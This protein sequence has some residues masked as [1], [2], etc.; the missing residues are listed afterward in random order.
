MP[1]MGRAQSDGKVQL[2]GSVQ[3]EFTVPEEDKAIGT[4]PS[5][6]DV[7]NNTYIDLGLTSKYID[8]GARLE[9]MEHPLQGFEEDFKGWGVPHIYIKGRYKGMEL[10]VGDYYEQFGSGLILRS[11]EERS[12]GIDNS[13]RGGRLKVDAIKGLHLT[14]LAGTQRRY[15]D[16]EYKNCIMGADAELSISDLAPA[17]QEKGI[18]W[19]IGG[20]WVDKY[21]HEDA[22]NM[23]YSKLNIPKFTNSFDVRSRLQ[24]QNFS[25]LAEYAW[26]DEDPS[27]VNNYTYHRG[28]AI[29]VSASYSKT[30]FSA[31]VQAKRSE[32]MNYR[33]QRAVSGTSCFVNH[34]PAFAYQHTYS[35]AALYPYSTQYGSASAEYGL[36]PGEWAFQGEVAY[37]FKKKTALGGKYG[38]KLKFNASHIRGL[39]YELTD[40]V[41]GSLSGTD[42]YK[43]KFFGTSN[44]S[45]YEDYNIQLDKKI[46]KQLKVNAMYMYQKYNKTVVE[47]HGGNVYSHIFVG[48][49]KYQF[50]KTWTLRAEAQYLLTAHESGDWGFGLLELSMAPN[51]M[52]T[53]SDQ[54]GR[55]E[56]DDYANV[57]HYYNAMLTYNLGAHRF[58]ASYGRT[59]AGYNCAGGVCRYI[60][61]N[62][63]FGLTYNYTF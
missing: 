21:E 18:D 37:T 58:T 13:L 59:R 2:H 33:S 55:P 42:G 43:A 47:G 20:S 60:P 38:T 31:L 56:V 26:K 29:F 30:G 14:A 61:A 41:N 6:D 22:E 10:T 17:W 48:E 24:V 16:W 25:L 23:M 28:N 5:S 50:N 51:W 44:D 4:T 7:L 40:K 34:M 27:A 8:A 63:G 62:K 15:W 11:Y 45:Y 39:K 57:E 12:L 46:S 52:L 3:S 54:I 35:L 32:S 19:M 53:L 49:G 9:Y 36:V 1:Q